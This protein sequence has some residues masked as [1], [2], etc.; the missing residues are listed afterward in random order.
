MGLPY[1]IAYKPG[2]IKTENLF[3]FVV[4]HLKRNRKF[5]NCVKQI[6]Y[7]KSLNLWS[8]KHLFVYGS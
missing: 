2:I 4:H 7:A 8:V 5:F 3:C 6:N 1:F